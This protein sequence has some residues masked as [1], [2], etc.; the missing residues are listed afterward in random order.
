MMSISMPAMSATTGP[1]LRLK[2]MWILL[3][4]RAVRHGAHGRQ[5]ESRERARAWGV[6]GIA[7]YTACMMG[8]PCRSCFEE[9]RMLIRDILRLKGERIF[10]IEPSG[11]LTDAVAQ[12]AE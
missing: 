3:H 5:Q 12:M 2:L 6:S 1:T 11:S 4:G 7:F 9:V 10:S 8:L